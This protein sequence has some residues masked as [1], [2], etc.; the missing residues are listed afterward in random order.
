MI[1]LTLELLHEAGTYALGLR[2]LTLA[3]AMRAIFNMIRIVSAGAAAMRANSLAR[4][5]HVH[6]LTLIQVSE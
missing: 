1:A 4:V 6:L 5:F 2:H 3:T